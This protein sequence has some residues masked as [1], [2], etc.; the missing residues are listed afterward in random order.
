MTDAATGPGGVQP[1][2]R[3]ADLRLARLH[4]RT[5]AFALAR[6]ELESL[7]GAAALDEERSSIWPRFAGGPMI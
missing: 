5:G 7:A 4:L 3:S 6:A 2:D 1:T